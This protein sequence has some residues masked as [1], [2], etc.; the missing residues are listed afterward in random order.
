[1]GEAVRFAAYDRRLWQAGAES[2]PQPFPE[3]FP[4]QIWP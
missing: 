2:G 1:M 3:N 4:T